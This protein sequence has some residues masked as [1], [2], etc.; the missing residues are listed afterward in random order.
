MTTYIKFRMA[1]KLINA[2]VKSFFHFQ[3]DFMVSE[4]VI[5]PSRVMEKA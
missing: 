5:A 2:N 3:E 1:L 4:E